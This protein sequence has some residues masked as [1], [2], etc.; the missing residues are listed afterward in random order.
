MKTSY[1]PEQLEAF[2]R[3]MRE[4]DPDDPMGGTYLLGWFLI[5]ALMTLVVLAVY[6]LSSCVPGVTQIFPAVRG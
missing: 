2:R 3:A 1:T 5:L 4:A 6:G